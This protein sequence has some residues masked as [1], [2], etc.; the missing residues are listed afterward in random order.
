[1]KC[2]LTAKRLREAMNDIGIKQRELADQAK[3]HETSVS[4][5]V[6]GTHAPSNISAGKLAEVLGVSPVWLM[7]YDVPKR[8]VP[9]VEEHLSSAE[10]KLIRLFRTLNE[11]GRAKILS[12]I[13]DISELPKYQ[14]NIDQIT[15]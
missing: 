4:Q 14:K 2:E 7:G 1:M 10:A 12:D 3:I 13:T 6:N 5:Y 15:A 8:E 11:D 9:T